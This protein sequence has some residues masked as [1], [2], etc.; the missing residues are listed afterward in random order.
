MSEKKTY[1][2]IVVITDSIDYVTYQFSLTVADNLAPKLNSSVD[3]P[4]NIIFGI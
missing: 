2:M 3:S 1:K 4:V